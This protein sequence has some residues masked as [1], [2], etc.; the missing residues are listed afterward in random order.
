V[1]TDPF[2]APT[3]AGLAAAHAVRG[4]ARLADADIARCLAVLPGWRRVD[5]RIEKTFRFADYEQTIA[6]VDAVARIAIG[7]DHHPDLS[8]HYGRCV[9]S[10]TTH[11][12]GGISGND[13]VFA[14][15]VERLAA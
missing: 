15:K 14:A 9:V 13:A 1:A 2:A 7:E 11:D 8:V 12:A 6:F 5:D 3:T 10:L 4:A